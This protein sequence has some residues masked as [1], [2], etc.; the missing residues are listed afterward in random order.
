MMNVP[1]SQLF[2][3][4]NKSCKEAQYNESHRPRV[5]FALWLGDQ[6][7][8]SQESHFSLSVALLVPSSSVSLPLLGC[9]V[10]M[11]PFRRYF[12]H[13]NMEDYL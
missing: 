13:N 9:C 12:F 8:C 10:F 2:Q 5:L 11:I 6:S 3:Q 4:E 7:K 1:L